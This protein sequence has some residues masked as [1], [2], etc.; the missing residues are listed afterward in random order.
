MMQRFGFANPMQVPKVMKVTI[1]VGYGRHVKDKAY[2]ENVEKTLTLIT[3]Q[4][5]VHNKAKKSISNFKIRAGM[6][7][8]ISAALRGARMYEF[9]YKLIH[10]TFPRTR[11]FRGIR[12][13]GF[14][15]QGNYTVGLKEN[16]AFPEITAEGSEKI[17]GLEIVITTSAKN[18]EQGF[19]L[20]KEMGFPFTEK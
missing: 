11:D 14:D 17:H 9:L 3:G 2:V 18:K 5:P 16:I 12:P 1:N 10:L 7:I 19:A 13:K 4:K 20:L 15:A 8:G 6:P